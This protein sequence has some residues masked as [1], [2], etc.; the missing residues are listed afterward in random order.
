MIAQWSAGMKTA[1]TMIAFGAGSSAPC[2]AP[3]EA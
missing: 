1:M 2:P 3:Q